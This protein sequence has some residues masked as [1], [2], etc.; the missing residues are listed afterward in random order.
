MSVMHEPV[1]D[2]VGDGGITLCCSKQ[3]HESCPNWL[4]SAYNSCIQYRFHAGS[5]VRPAVLYARNGAANE[6]VDLA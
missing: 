1:E 3:P 5:G 2:T 4:K 6:W